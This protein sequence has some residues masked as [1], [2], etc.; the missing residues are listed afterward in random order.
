MWPGNGVLGKRRTRSTLQL[1]PGTQ[2]V[3]W[4]WCSGKTKNTKGPTIGSGHSTCDLGM[5]FREHE[6]HEVAY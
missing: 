2:N 4:E 1:A 5:A 3:A 6:E